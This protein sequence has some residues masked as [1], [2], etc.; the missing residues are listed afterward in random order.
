MKNIFLKS[1]KQILFVAVL[2]AGLSFASCKL[3]PP[4]GPGRG[5]NGGGNGGGRDTTRHGGNGGGRG[6]NGGGN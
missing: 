1:T 2:A 5:G 6:G 4:T 3:D